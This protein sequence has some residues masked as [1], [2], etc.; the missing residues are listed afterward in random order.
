MFKKRIFKAAVKFIENK[1]LDK[2][3]DDLEAVLTKLLIKCAEAIFK[4][5][6]TRELVVAAL[7]DHLES[8]QGEG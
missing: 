2:I 1:V 4:N 6:I 7:E 5:E 3:D 8:L